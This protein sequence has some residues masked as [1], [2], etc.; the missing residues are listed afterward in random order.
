MVKTIMGSN[1]ADAR[2]IQV[3]RMPRIPSSEA[4]L[5]GMQGYGNTRLRV[6]IAVGLAGILAGCVSSGTK[7]TQAQI[8]AFQ[9]G[10]TTEAE[11]ISAFGPPN[12]AS[13]L[14]DGS[15]IDVYVHMSAHAN[16][17]SYV[18]V[19]GLFAGGAKGD[20][21]TAVFTFGPN[22]ILKATSSSAAHTDVNT[23]LANQK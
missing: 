22:G 9:V 18:P 7:V 14:S 10:N 6:L 15:R 8:S 20:S 1:H 3:Q 17:A 12:S 16:A 23:G 2:E 21:E 11:V 5:S 19:V 4:G 13:V